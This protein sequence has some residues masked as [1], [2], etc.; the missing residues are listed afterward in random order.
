VYVE[1]SNINK[2][3]GKL[4]V[5]TF[6]GSLIIQSFSR[7][8]LGVFWF[9]LFQAT[10]MVSSLLIKEDFLARV[11][12]EGCLLSLIPIRKNSPSNGRRK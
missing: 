1:G 9:L 6:R 2:K 8:Y 7:T 4:T 11:E 12:L 10:L 3:F 5:F